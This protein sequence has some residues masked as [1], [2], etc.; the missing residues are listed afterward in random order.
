MLR[1]DHQGAR[2]QLVLGRTQLGR[3]SVS[4]QAECGRCLQQRG[5]QGE[6]SV[7]KMGSGTA[8]HIRSVSSLCW[9]KPNEKM[10]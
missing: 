4:R 2:G 9:S 8:A 1:E 7:R 10:R 6:T 3:G 5:P